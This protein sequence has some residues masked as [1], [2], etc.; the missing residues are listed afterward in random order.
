MRKTIILLAATLGLTIA[1]EAS[2]FKA[3]N[4]DVEF[5]HK[6]HRGKFP[7]SDCHE[8]SPR[9][10]DLDKASAHKLCIGCHKKVNAGPAQHCSDCHKFSN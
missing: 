4:G 7:C 1:A 9:H 5:D 10:F 2:V 3:Y 8:G 6:L